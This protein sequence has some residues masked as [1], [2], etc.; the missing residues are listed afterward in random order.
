MGSEFFASDSRVT[1]FRY[2]GSLLHCLGVLLSQRCSMMFVWFHCTA[3]SMPPDRFC[4]KASCACSMTVS[5]KVSYVAKG[6]LLDLCFAFRYLEWLLFLLN[7]EKYSNIMKIPPISVLFRLKKWL[8]MT[9]QS[10][11][12]TLVAITSR[13]W[14]CSCVF[15]LY[16]ENTKKCMKNALGG[17]QISYIPLPGSSQVWASSLLALPGFLCIFVI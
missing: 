8:D 2:F 6:E 4:F 9:Y 16:N 13:I 1:A 12:S 7:T 5:I 3:L 10:L 14:P 11:G 17:L 15:R